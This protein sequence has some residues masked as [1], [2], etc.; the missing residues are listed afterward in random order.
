MVQ[1][2]IQVLSLMSFVRKVGSREHLSDFAAKTYLVNKSMQILTG[3]SILKE[4][5][6]Y[7]KSKK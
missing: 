2:V 3:L 5:D 4:N 7:H 6:L 1:Y